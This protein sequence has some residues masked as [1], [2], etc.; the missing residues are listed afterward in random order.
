MVGFRFL[1]C[2]SRS[3]NIDCANANI[4]DVDRFPS[5]PV[6]L[7]G[8]R[9]LLSSAVPVHVGAVLNPMYD[10]GLGVV[11]Y[12]VDDPVIAPA[13]RIKAVEFPDQLRA[14]SLRVFSNRPRQCAQ[15]GVTNFGREMVEVEKTFRCDSYFIHGVGPFPHR[16]GER[17][18]HVLIRL[19]ISQASRKVRCPLVCRA[20][21]RVNQDRPDL[22]VRTMVV[23]Y[24]SPRSVRVRAQPVRPTLTSVPSRQ[25]MPS[26]KSLV[27]ILT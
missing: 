20:S 9:R 22:G 1:L 24:A 5:S 21:L 27:K 11:N 16:A 13:R 15:R 26:T 25:R 14:E 10:H 18:R 7:A 2:P 6:A 19:A 4:G 23:H 12:L 17:S 8:T 3:T